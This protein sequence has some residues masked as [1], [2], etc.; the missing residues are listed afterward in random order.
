MKTTR[1]NC[2]ETNSSSTHAYS[3]NTFKEESWKLSQTFIPDENNQI[4]VEISDLDNVENSMAGKLQFLV[5]VAYHKG[6]QHAFDRIKRAVKDFTNADLIVNKP[7]SWRDDTSILNV[8][9]VNNI[10]EDEI[11]DYL[12]DTFNRFTRED[13]GSVDELILNFNTYTKSENSIKAFIFSNFAP[14]EK[15][16]YYDG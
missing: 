3:L 6:D 12:D 16:E 9:A 5:S 7:K 15:Q 1:S 8:K 2:F 14:F 4:H 11:R 10:L 13:Y